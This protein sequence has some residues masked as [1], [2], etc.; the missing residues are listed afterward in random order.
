MVTVEVTEDQT[1]GKYIATKK[2][3]KVKE[4]AEAADSTAVS[5]TEIT[6]KNTYKTTPVTVPISAS[7]SLEGM[8]LSAGQF[9]FTLEPYSTNENDTNVKQEKRNDGQGKIT[10]D[11]LKYSAPGIYKY[12]VTETSKS[13]NGMTVDSTAY[14]V[15][16]TVTDNQEGALIYEKEILKGTASADAIIFTNKYVPTSTTAKVEAK[17]TLNGNRTIA[18]GEFSFSLTPTK[19]TGPNLEREKETDPPTV[20]IDDPNS[21]QTAS[22]VGNKVAFSE[23]VYTRPG[24]YEYSLKETTVASDSLTVD[25]TE[26]LVKVTVTDDGK[27]KLSSV[28]TYHKP[29]TTQTGSETEYEQVNE[30]EFVNTYKSG[31]LKLKKTVDGNMASVDNGTFTFDITLLQGTKPV[32][33]TF[34]YSIGNGSNKTITFDENGIGTLTLKKSEEAEIIGLPNGASYT[35]TERAQSGY[36]TSW[37]NDTNSGT[38]NETTSAEIECI[39]TRDAY[40][41]MTIVKK[42]T[43]NA[44][45]LEKKF[46]ITLQIWKE[47]N[48]SNG[49]VTG[50]HGD[51]TLDDEGKATIPLGSNESAFISGLPYGAYY[52]ITETIAA[53]DGYVP[54]MTLI[55]NKSNEGE[56]TTDSDGSIIGKGTIK[57]TYVEDKILVATIA[58]H[59]DRFG[60]FKLT[61]SV[62]A[63]DGK[64]LNTV[65]AAA[66]TK[67]FSFSITLS[68]STLNGEYGTITRQGSS[69]EK[70]RFSGGKAT[71][72]LANNETAAVFPLPDGTSYTITEADYTDD[73]YT[74]TQRTITGKVVGTQASA[75]SV[76][77]DIL[78]TSNVITAKNI[79]TLRGNLV[80]TKAVEGNMK[81]TVIRAKTEFTIKV[82]LGGDKWKDNTKIVN[83]KYTY[84]AMAFGED[85][86]CEFKLKAGDSKTGSGIPNGVPYTIQE[87]FNDSITN[88]GYVSETLINGVIEADNTGTINARGQNNVLITNRKDMFGG[89]KIVKVTAGSDP[90]KKTWFAMKVELSDKTINGQYG[91]VTFI[92]GVST[93]PAGTTDK[94]YTNGKVP[95]GYFKVTKATPVYVLGL[96][97]GVTYTVTEDLYTSTYDSQ[98]PTNTSGTITGIAATR[99]GVTRETLENSSDLTTLTATWTNTR[100][101]TGKLVIRKT[102]TGDVADDGRA[103]TINIT[104]NDKDGRG[105]NGTYD[106]VT[107]NGGKATVEVKAREER[108]IAGLP[109]NATF[110]VTETI[111]DGY[112]DPAYE[113]SYRE[114]V[115]DSNGDQVKDAD[116]KTVKIDRAFIW[117]GTTWAEDAQ[118][119]PDATIQVDQ[120]VVTVTNQIT[121]VKIAKVDLTDTNKM[122]AGATFQL[123]EGNGQTPVKE[124]ETTDVAE[125]ITGL[126]TKTTY[127][128]HEKYAPDGY[129]LMPDVLFT[130]DGK[131]EVS[132]N[133]AENASLDTNGVLR[134]TNEKASI[135]NFEKKILDVND[136]ETKALTTPSDLISATAWQDSA[137]YDIGDPVPYKLTATLAN[138]VTDY[139]KYHITFHD[140]MEESLNLDPDSIL[141]RVDGKTV[142]A[143]N[144]TVSKTPGLH[145]FDVT[146]TWEG[147]RDGNG[148]YTG[149]ITEDLNG[150][151]VEL[152]FFATLNEKAKLGKPGNVNTALLKYSTNPKLDENGNPADDDHERN[153]KSTPED[154]VIAFTYK[155]EIKKTDGTNALPGAAFTLEKKLHDNSWKTISIDAASTET[156]FVYKGLDDGIYR[157]TETTTPTGYEKIAPIIFEVKATHS[158]IWDVSSAQAVAESREKVLTDL[159]ED[160]KEGKL[161][162]TKEKDLSRLTGTVVNLPS[163]V[164]VGVHK[165]W[166]DGENC[167]G[168]RPLTLTVKLLAN[169]QVYSTETL[170]ATNNWTLVK[171]DLPMLDAAG[172]EIVYT[173]EEVTPAGY[174][175]ESTATSG[176]LTTLTNVNT[177]EKTSVS[178]KKVWNDNGNA[179]KTRPESIKVQLFAN[180]KAEG[181]PVTLDA[182]NGWAASWT[183]L[184]KYKNGKTIR[185]T[186]EEV[187]VPAGYTAKVSGN[188]ADGFVITN[189]IT[190]ASLTIE[191]NFSFGGKN[192]EELETRIEVPVQKVWVDFNNRDKN[193]PD[194]I[195]VHLYA[196]GER[197]ATASLTE[198]GGW[199]NTFRDLPKYN[200]ET[201]EEIVYT[202]SEEP[203]AYYQTEIN[204]YTIVNR[205]EPVL[206]DLSVSKIWDDDGN[207]MKIRPKSIHVT[208][209][210]GISVLLSASNGWTATITELPTVVNGQPVDYTWTEQEVP[211]YR[212]AGKTTAG[213]MTVFTNKVVKL[214]KVPA[215]QPQPKV[216]GAIWYV[217]EEYD[218]ALGGD[219]LINHVGDCFD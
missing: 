60:G 20:S 135:P 118:G 72:T 171:K 97:Y 91:D 122:L 65:N 10:F 52:E 96:P 99:E 6:F 143:V 132:I 137:D 208:L 56:V 17:K 22:N 169:G 209:S 195:T 120:R 33:G 215:D 37:K 123:F 218:T 152:Y 114:A 147:A 170:T 54:S 66:L 36:V 156:T 160:V 82:T 203:V 28:V 13:G 26:Y 144:A 16:I 219:V 110:T 124:W 150:K 196:D 157:L 86:V 42:V 70:I 23:M 158:A 45:D 32:S 142:D 204:H 176:T 40:G 201:F 190:L 68:D 193:R 92:N 102:M 9:L 189:S 71:I 159:S 155:M 202:I 1:N 14:T 21:A 49:Y 111:P 151:T 87:I 63:S 182:S 177:P 57:E 130:I 140:E 25:Q 191:K 172:K 67:Q 167:D 192:P 62:A 103:Y 117:M 73:G 136:S 174:M 119:A 121:T 104:V 216:P 198:A 186:V 211:G 43:G 197:V 199:K 64:E 50:K 34:N 88:D 166:K 162:L 108:T 109:L 38:I 179:G 75:D 175:L 48:K 76:T 8:N 51:V 127:R 80:V 78:D 173:W 165:V 181:K 81:D 7:K 69:T 113:L 3:V 84:G 207:D 61:K 112:I 27:G 46:D 44:A 30:A 59:L 100:N 217:F 55:S 128:I 126:K 206:V 24:T 205:Y 95:D 131:G 180:G 107:F 187:S 183:E 47:T 94:D 188:A 41:S 214:V 79:F 106:G 93:K 19:A 129:K 35:V 184:N 154:S 148:K 168:K 185:Y 178:V 161:V 53:Q 15:I 18:D 5:A 200:R 98:V 74:A 213:D 105:L 4:N 194:S 2:S 139:Y 145:G 146:L 101:R 11:T 83:G 134:I 115:R 138:N 163:S 164:S 116:G 212:Q 39:N 85:G 89:F 125:I 12:A 210:N 90:D 29:K 58:N 77:A 149:R 141:I 133:Q 31:S 153:E